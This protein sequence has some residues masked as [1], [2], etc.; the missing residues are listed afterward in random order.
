VGAYVYTKTGVNPFKESPLTVED[1]NLKDAFLSQHVYLCAHCKQHYKEEALIDSSIEGQ[2]V[3]WALNYDGQSIPVVCPKCKNNLKFTET[4]V[5]LITHSQSVNFEGE[6]ERLM[7]DPYPDA[8]LIQKV[9]LCYKCD[10]GECDGV[11]HVN[12]AGFKVTRLT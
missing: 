8:D 11:V 4:S 5:L 9:P 2:A 10:N 12:D 3:H 1:L 6:P 7:V